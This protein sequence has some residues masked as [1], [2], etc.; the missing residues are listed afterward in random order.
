MSGKQY[1]SHDGGVCG[2]VG[3]LV[4]VVVPLYSF[5]MADVAKI[6]ALAHWLTGLAGCDERETAGEMSQSDSDREMD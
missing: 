2:C 4:V 5:D 1:G 6:F 3:G